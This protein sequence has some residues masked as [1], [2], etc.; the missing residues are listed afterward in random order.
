MRADEPMPITDEIRCAIKKYA[1]KN[2]IDYGKADQKIVLNKMLQFP[3]ARGNMK[4]LGAEVGKIV[5]EINALSAEQVREQFKPFET[6]FEQKA[7]ETAEK[8]SKP[9]MVLEGATEGNVVTRLSPEPSGY[10]HIGHVKQALL[11]YEFTRIYKGKFY[12]YWDDTNPEKCKQEYVDAM[13][14]DH[15]W[16]GLKFDKEYYASDYVEQIYA[17]AKQLIEKGKAYVCLCIREEM[18]KKRY[19]GEECQHRNQSVMQNTELFND[20]LN[21]KLREGEAVLR[22]KGDMKAN[23][24]ALRDPAMLRI[25]TSPHYRQGT[26]Y[27]VWPLY[28]FNT[29]ILD[30]LNGITDII[31]SKE[32]ELR[33]ELG[34]QILE[35]LSLRVPRMH[36]EA[37]LNIKGNETHK[38]IIRKMIEDG[39]VQGWDDLRLMTIMSLRRR[40][41]Q[42]KAL[43]DFVLRFGMSKTDGEVG[44]EMLLAENK[45]IIDPIA[46]HLFFVSDPIKVMVKNSSIKEVKMKLHPSNNFGYRQYEIGDS[47]YISGEDSK[48]IKNGVVVRLKDLMDIRIKSKNG[49]IDAE[50][51][52]IPGTSI[53]Q[54]VSESNAVKCKIIIPGE[55]LDA[56]GN[57]NKDG[58]KTIEGFA[59]GY[60]NKLNEHDIVQFER[61]GYCILDNKE[62]QALQF[63]FISR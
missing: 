24:T 59:E 33:D 26:K 29:P 43:S 61:L 40:G 32:Y 38:R 60:A 57:F 16:L 2:A 52:E 31:R 1:I 17:Y 46:K 7:K 30:S 48:L 11:S 19:V 50:Q 18:Q 35:S 4:E 56:D 27:R 3:E 20:M 5:A 63:V 23:N 54:W 37:R 6:E 55:M 36:L 45:R 62:P 8:S 34:K 25:V 15:E 49:S 9:K 53:I 13:K 47:F 41:I 44:I 28:D 12:R 22:F 42:P 58:L 21:S 39:A 14:S 10:M 51:V